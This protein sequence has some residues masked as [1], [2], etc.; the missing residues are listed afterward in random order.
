VL[1]RLAAGSRES[2]LVL[3]TDN[4]TQF[5][6]ARFMETPARLG[7]THRRTAYHHPEGNS[8][9]DLTQQAQEKAAALV[10]R[11]AKE[12]KRRVLEQKRLPKRKR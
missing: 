8:Y 2:D 7:I 6:F 5:T 1:H 4:G 10:L 11:Q 12:G 9:I 3:T